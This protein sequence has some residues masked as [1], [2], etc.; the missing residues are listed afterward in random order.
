[1][2]LR[3][4][5][6]RWAPVVSAAVCVLLCLGPAGPGAWAATETYTYDNAGRLVVVDHGDGK[7]TTYTLDPAGNRTNVKTEIPGSTGTLTIAT[8]SSSYPESQGTVPI[9]IRRGSGTLGSAS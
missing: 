2:R 1:M 4:F 7:I 9:A 5:S 3:E 6:W 8:A